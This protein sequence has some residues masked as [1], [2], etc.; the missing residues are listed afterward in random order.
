MAIQINNKYIKNIIIGA[1][2]MTILGSTAAC[3]STESIATDVVQAAEPSISQAAVVSAEAYV[4][5]VNTANLS[6]EVGGRL[7]ALN[8]E[9]GQ[10][11]EAGDL[12]AEVDNR[13]QEIDLLEAEISLANME[14]S[15]IEA[16]ASLSQAQ[17]QLAEL[18]SG[19]TPEEIAQSE[20]SLAKAEATLADLLAGATAEEVA[21]ARAK[22]TTA[23]AN[24]SQ[25]LAGNRQE[26]IDAAAAT[27]LQAEADV[28]LAQADYDRFVYGDPQVA[29][30]YG[31]ALQQATLNYESAKASYDKLIAGPTDEEIAISEAQLNEA[32]V[33]LQ[34]TLAGP[35]AEQIAQTQAD[36]AQAEAALAALLADPKDETIAINQASIEAAQASVRKAELNIQSAQAGVDTAALALEKT[37]LTASFD[38]IIG[39]LDLTE[40]ELVQ[41]SATAI[42]LG[43]ISKWQIETDDLNEIDVV[44]VKL[45]RNV[46]I[47]ID[48][49]PDET[50]TGTVISVSPQ[51]ELKAGDVTY[52]VVIDIVDGPVEKLRWGM[53]A[54]VDIDAN[55]DL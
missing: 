50:F 29:E 7:V 19:A 47:N 49:L 3:G 55:P 20:A 40:G 2:A 6:F 37:Q 22:I 8:V 35:T 45:G 15:L 44:Q 18:K 30:P 43:D 5:P 17:A 42:T 12:L 1:V 32:Q 54:F 31:V 51:S 27:M 23:E 9:E 33:A 53:T 26:D 52:T 14:A 21:E 13:S 4:V 16:Q 34:R 48:A 10:S 28:R 38:G 39:N 11:V 24:L 25:V 36:V 41:A 46:D